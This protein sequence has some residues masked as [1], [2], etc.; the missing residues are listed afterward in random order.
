MSAPG[1]F[2][3]QPWP[4]S[5]V[6]EPAAS[7]APHAALTCPEA[8]PA[9]PL[10]SRAFVQ[11]DQLGIFPN[12]SW[13]LW[14]GERGELQQGLAGSECPQ[15]A[16]CPRGAGRVWISFVTRQFPITPPFPRVGLVLEWAQ[17][18]SDHPG[19]GEGEQDGSEEWERGN[20]SQ[21]MWIRT[22]S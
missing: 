20:S 11:W 19:G 5:R 18:L 6:P 1:V 9:S 10:T 13:E 2:R 8:A 16:L 22:H 7:A 15:L 14:E 12:I 17:D 21:E 3:G 4:Q